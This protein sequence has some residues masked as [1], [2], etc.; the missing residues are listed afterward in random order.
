MTRDEM[1]AALAVQ[2]RAL[3]D[4]LDELSD[5]QWATP[6]LCAGWSVVDVLGHLVSLYDVPT[7]RFVVG[8]MGM[9][10]F[11]RR[12]DGFARHYGRRGPQELL[13]MYRGMADLRKAPP[14]I[15]PIA[16][17]SDAV[18]HALDMGRP[19]GLAPVH[20]ADAARAALGALSR[21]LAGFNSKKQVR[22]LR[23]EATDLEWS[24]GEGPVVRG[25]AAAVLLA[26]AGRSAAL[27]DLE[28]DGV[29]VLAARAA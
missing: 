29:S 2:R 14:V 6:S 26:L 16:P 22:G 28:G 10:G 19:L 21:G 13:A 7:W 23:Y 11:H 12:V 3:C 15:G 17:L 24:A 25:P 4:Q 27:A 9:S 8:T 5:E 1:F 20:S 18:V